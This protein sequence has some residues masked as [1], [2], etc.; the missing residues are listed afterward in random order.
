[1]K[2]K[3]C[4]FAGTTEGRRLAELLH[5]EY[6]LTVCVAT[7]YGEILLDGIPDITVRPGRMDEAA[8]E[9]FLRE[10]GFDRVIDATH[11]YAD[12]V[13]ENIRTAA[14]KNSLPLL[15]VLRE[16]E[17]ASGQILFV[18]SAEEAA[19][20]LSGTEGNIL[21]TTG[22]KDLPAYAGLGADRLWA[23]VLPAAASLES[24][25]AIGLLPS[26]ILAVQGPFS[27]E[28]NLAMIHMTDAR[29]LVTKDSGKNGGFREKLG[30]AA[31]AGILTVIIGKPPQTRGVSFEE[32]V[33]LLNGE[34]EK[35]RVRVIGIGP[36]GRQLLTAEAEK[37]L[38]SCDAVIGAASVTDAVRTDKP[39]FHAFQP[40]AVRAVLAEHPSFREVCVAMRGDTGFFSGARNLK[41]ALGEYRVEILPGISSVACLA[42]RL[43]IAW[44]DA[45]LIS[46]HSRE[47]A[48]IRTVLTSPGTFVLSGG[49]N[50]VSAI[51]GRL[52]EYGL[53]ALSVTV[54]ENLS[55][56]EE[57]ICRGSAETFRETGFAPLSLLYIENP[58]ACRPF[59]VGIPDEEFIRG[60]VPMTKS[61][62]R[63]VSLSRLAPDDGAVV[64]DIG[65]GTGSVAVECALNVPRGRVWAVEKKAEAVSLIRENRRRR[66]PAGSN[67]LP[68]RT[69]D[70][71]RR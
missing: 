24:C 6:D 22:S 61:E 58:S 12:R 37:A 57:R 59:R 13:T 19:E 43:G 45:A 20:L 63:A 28:M 62:V 67:R 5:G 52:C 32:A 11:P 9:S 15:R 40:E 30:A 38:R 14:E 34:K 36:G 55:L 48:L 65:A 70:R 7:E 10:G 41:E 49:S 31:E 29:F 66:S 3:I 17:P 21:L 56:P 53:G 27:R 39:V 18:R 35:T 47:G 26:H 8:M 2:E 33:H 68:Y 16:S 25:A 60:D 64:Y 54:G 4:L 69:T 46:L 51:C 1:M 23:R 42:A 44:D 50:S 71:L